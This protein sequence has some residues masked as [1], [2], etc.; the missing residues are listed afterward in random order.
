MQYSPV[1]HWTKG[2]GSYATEM[3]K[4]SQEVFTEKALGFLESHRDKPFFLY[5]APIIPHDNGEAQDM[6]ARYKLPSYAPYENM[7]WTEDEKGYAANITYLDRE[8]GKLMDKLKALGLEENTLII[9]TSDNGG[10]SPGRFHNLSNQPLR[11]HKRDLYEGGLRV[12]MIAR[13]KGTVPAGAVSDH[14]SANW[15]FL[16]TF[17]ELA[18]IPAPATTDGISVAP[19][20]LEKGRQPQHDHLYWEF[21]KQGKKQ[22][23]LKGPWKAVRL[24][25]FPQ[26]A[27]PDRTLQP[28]NRPGRNPRRF[29]A[30]PRNRRGLTQMM[31]SSRT[32]D[33]NWKW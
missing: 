6:N 15:D 27:R 24:D 8:V 22:A 32:E 3:K 18:G 4:N 9:F 30:T 16:P 13:W 7:P 5:F 25:V 21:H 20:L 29:R 31:D 10:D 14:V 33:P 19:T 1:T 2:L 23:V 17:C 28:R 26:S 12:P 11:G